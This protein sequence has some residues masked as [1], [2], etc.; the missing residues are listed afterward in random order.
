MS[1]FSRDERTARTLAISAS[2]LAS[3][4]LEA[5][6]ASLPRVL[7]Y[8]FWADLISATSSKKL[9]GSMPALFCV[10]APGRIRT[11]VLRH[12]CMAAPALLSWAT[13]ACGDRRS[14]TAATR[15]WKEP[16]PV[17]ARAGTGLPSFEVA[18]VPPVLPRRAFR[19]FGRLRGAVADKRPEVDPHQRSRRPAVPAKSEQT[20][21]G[22]PPAG[23]DHLARRQPVLFREVVEPAVLH[24]AISVRVW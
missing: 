3:S 11:A 10:S 18:V 17:F 1:A 9:L 22:C 19:R 12:G 5:T 4:V 20:Y 13:G 24:H 16:S 21:H 14:G 6:S 23:P 7:K 8:D 15:L 2:T